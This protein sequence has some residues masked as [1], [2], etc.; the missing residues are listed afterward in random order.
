MAH[1]IK[2]WMKFFFPCL[3][4]FL[5]MLLQLLR[6]VRRLY[7]C[8][9]FDLQTCI[10]ESDACSVPSSGTWRYFAPLVSG[11]T[12]WSSFCLRSPSALNAPAHTMPCFFTLSRMTSFSASSIRSRECKASCSASS[13]T[14]SDGSCCPIPEGA[15]RR[16][17]R[18]RRSQRNR[19]FDEY[20]RTSRASEMPA[21]I[22]GSTPSMNL[23]P[24]QTMHQLVRNPVYAGTHLA[25]KAVSK[26]S[27]SQTARDMKNNPEDPRPG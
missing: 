14:M 24:S 13:S 8:L 20:R 1:A 9:S 6:L 7:L 10:H 11:F 22:R 19:Y 16:C 17:L 15:R 18:R 27:P 26:S 12:W 5:N 21:R 4:I 3:Y 2:A 23:F 25:R